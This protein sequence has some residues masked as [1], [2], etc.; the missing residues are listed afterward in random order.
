MNKQK[1]ELPRLQNKR[2]NTIK[3]EMQSLL[4]IESGNCSCGKH[5][6]EEKKSNDNNEK[7]L[8]PK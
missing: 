5:L 6:T 7:M 8:F 1:L 2:I 3:T 4:K